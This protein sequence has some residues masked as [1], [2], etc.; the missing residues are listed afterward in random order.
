MIARSSSPFSRPR[1]SWSWVFSATST[2]AS[3]CAWVNS[4][5]STGSTVG[6]SEG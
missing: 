5:S 1:V 4:L 3:G 6:A 2:R